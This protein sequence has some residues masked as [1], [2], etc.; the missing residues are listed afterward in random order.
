MAEKITGG[1]IRMA[2]AFLRWSLADLGQH[3]GL[4]YSTLREIEAADDPADT[5]GGVETTREYRAGAR[6]ESLGKITAAFVK[7]GVTFLPDDGKLGPGIRVK[8]KAKGK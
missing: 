2:R 7:A 3:S 6:A 4:N 8:P 1:Q 5:A